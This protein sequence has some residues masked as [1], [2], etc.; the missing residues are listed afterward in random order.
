MRYWRKEDVAALIGVT[1]RTIENEMTRGHLVPT[2]FGRTVRFT[3]DSVQQ[4]L[5]FSRAA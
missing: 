3:D 5:Q 4:F 1:S 2:R